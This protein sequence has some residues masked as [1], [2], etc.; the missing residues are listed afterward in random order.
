MILQD[1]EVADECVKTVGGDR[2]RAVVHRAETLNQDGE[3]VLNMW[4]LFLMDDSFGGLLIRGGVV[5]GAGGIQFLQFPST[6]F[7]SF[8]PP[9]HSSSA[10]AVEMN[11]PVSGTVVPREQTE[12]SLARKAR[13][14]R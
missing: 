10:S 4:V 9:H 11:L 7:Y 2:E 5:V 8:Y 13:V 6:P 12:V 3:A 1:F 14:A